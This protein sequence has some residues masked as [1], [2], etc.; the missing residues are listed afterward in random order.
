MRA[1][2]VRADSGSAPM[3]EETHMQVDIPEIMQAVEIPR[4][5]PAEVLRVVSRP[6]PKPAAGEV[7]VRVVAAGV[8]KVDTL[9]RAGGFPPP[10]G[11]TDI[12]GV[13][14]SGKVVATG[15]GM[16]RNRV[17]DEVCALAAGGGYAEYAVVRDELTLPVPAGVTLVDA[18]GLPEAYF[19][20]WLHLVENG[21]MRPG[22]TVLVHGGTSGIGSAAIQLATAMGGTVWA[23]AG[24]DEKCRACE[25][26]GA[27]SAINYRKQDFVEAV[28]AATA[29]R[30]V[31]L[32]VDIVGGDYVARNYE[33]TAEGGRI[34]QVGF[35]AGRMANVD[36]VRLM[37]RRLSHI[38]GSL[39]PQSDDAKAAIA[40]GLHEKVWPLFPER[41]LRPV[42]D[43]T[44]ELRDAAQAHRRLESSDHIGKILLLP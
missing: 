25:E 22:L 43:S 36:L 12:P 24:T 42:T 39:R 2:P 23:T 31:D 6:T 8:N 40:R 13:E 18:A 14:I 35:M 7:L 16:T 21:R 37:R 30:G 32:L 4:P 17:G 26:L 38:G 15:G 10:S 3:K 19:T 11:A 28:H 33:A 29:G 1:G 41:R 9:Q 5:G 20:L 27:V 44:F 34:L